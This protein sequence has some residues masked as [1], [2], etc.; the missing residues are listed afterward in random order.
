MEKLK[1]WYYTTIKTE[2][3]ETQVFDNYPDEIEHVGK[4]RTIRLTK[5]YFEKI[6][7]DLDYGD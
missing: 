1:I 2:D 3:N 7:K 6:T 5:D 4:K